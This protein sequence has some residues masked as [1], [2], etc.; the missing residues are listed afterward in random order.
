MLNE[1]YPYECLTWVQIDGVRAYGIVRKL[2]DRP[3]VCFLLM[4]LHA[5]HTALSFMYYL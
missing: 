1:D 2:L 4:N 3:S 5:V